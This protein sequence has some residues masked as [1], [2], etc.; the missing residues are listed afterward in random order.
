MLGRGVGEEI[1]SIRPEEPWGDVLP[2]LS[3]ADARIANLECCVSA[4]GLPWT[5]TPKVFHFRAP[6]VAVDVLRAARITAVSLANNHV[7]DYGEDALLD[8]LELLDA[9]GIA[10]A[11]AGL[12]LAQARKPA[13]IRAGA[14]RVG[15]LAFTDNEPAFAATEGR[16]GTNFLEV[17]LEPPALRV[18]EAAIMEARAAGAEIVILSN[19]WGP[20]MV[21]RPSRLFREFARAVIDLGA[22]VYYG[23]SAHLFQGV[24]LYRGRWILYDTGDF[25][26]DYAVDPLLRNDWSFLFRISARELQSRLELFPVSLSFSR[27]DRA[28]AEDRER[29]LQKMTRLSLELETPLERVGDHLEASAMPGAPAYDWEAPP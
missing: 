26:N 11:G 15:L 10:H 14:T 8:T 17:S 22:D 2:L 16:P 25:L 20:N 24:E 12:N 29:I 6:P 9:V 3:N 21:Q 5:R 18:V 13:I 4:R 27:V 19:H 7:L 28:V 1:R 23:H